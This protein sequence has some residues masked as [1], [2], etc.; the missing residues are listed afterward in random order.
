MTASSDL[1]AQGRP[2]PIHASGPEPTP[3][4]WGLDR[5]LGN[6]ARHGGVVETRT[7]RDWLQHGNRTAQYRARQ[8]AL[9][10]I[11][12]QAATI[13]ALEADKA[14]LFE[15]LDDLT[16]A[17]AEFFR[18]IPALEQCVSNALITLAKHGGDK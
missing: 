11:E 4:A 8:A 17:A 12:A 13:L 6:S 9:A 14:A 3:M 15:A 1:V 2:V 18:P 7:L 5:P 10:L 16:H